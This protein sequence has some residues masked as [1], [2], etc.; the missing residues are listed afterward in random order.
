MLQID[1]KNT[2]KTIEKWAKYLNKNIT[3][4]EIQLANKQM[5]R[6]NYFLPFKVEKQSRKTIMRTPSPGKNEWKH[7]VSHMVKR[8]V[9]E[10]SPDVIKQKNTCVGT[11]NPPWKCQPIEIKALVCT[12][13]GIKFIIAVPVMSKNPPLTTKSKKK[14]NHHEQ[15]WFKRN[16]ILWC[17]IWREY[18]HDLLLKETSTLPNAV[19]AF[20][21][22]VLAFWTSKVRRSRTQNR[23]GPL[24]SLREVWEMWRRKL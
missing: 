1:K 21:L 18:D 3:E 13:Y 14:Q 15:T 8:C 19:C 16:H 6:W 12:N 5:T 22:D 23:I 24:V 10:P 2:N 11:A 20:D 9:W 4:E 17:K 7:P